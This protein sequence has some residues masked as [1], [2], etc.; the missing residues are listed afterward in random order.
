M[1]PRKEPEASQRP[2]RRPATTP[3]GRMQQM[4]ALA[5]EL[6][7]KQM[8][9]GTASAQVITHYLTQTTNREA[10]EQ[11]KIRQENLRLEAQIAQINAQ[12]GSTELA[13]EVIAMLT[14]YQGSDDDDDV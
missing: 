6:A 8:I 10:L 11:E 9:A 1:P 12:S 3:E 7:E 4:G 2:A 14:V 5:E 13:A